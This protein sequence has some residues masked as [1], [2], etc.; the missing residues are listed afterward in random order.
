MSRT[1]GRWTSWRLPQP[2]GSLARTRVGCQS[3]AHPLRSQGRPDAG[4]R[5]RPSRLGR[6]TGVTIL[7]IY[8]RL[9]PDPG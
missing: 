9:W 2:P 1:R 8:K 7:S 4:P 3:V 5:R 6:Q